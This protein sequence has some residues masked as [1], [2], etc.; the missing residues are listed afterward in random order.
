M[1]LVRQVFWNVQRKVRLLRLQSV[2]HVA[3]H[4]IGSLVLPRSRPASR[5]ETTFGSK[6]T[7]TKAFRIETRNNKSV[8]VTLTVEDQVPLTSDNSI[9]V[10]VEELS[11]A[12]YD[13]ES[14]L[15]SWTFTL[16]PGETRTLNLRFV[17][18][19][20]KKKV[21]DGL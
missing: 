11:G 1:T 16:Q 21:I 15:V 19:Y 14:G 5:Y 20:P 13:D 9:E 3:S 2:L 10:S 17:V 12:K 4:C 7:T 8:P 6:K 18:K